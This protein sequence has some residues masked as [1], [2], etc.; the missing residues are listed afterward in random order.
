MFNEFLADSK[1]LKIQLIL[2]LKILNI[3]LFINC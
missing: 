2:Y 3:I 1:K